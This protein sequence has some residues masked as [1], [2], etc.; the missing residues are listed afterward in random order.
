MQ[1]AQCLMR[2]EAEE[3][4]VRPIVHP[5]IRALSSFLLETGTPQLDPPCKPSR[6]PD[7]FRIIELQSLVE[8][9]R[10]FF[11][12]PRGGCIQ[13]VENILDLLLPGRAKA[14]TM[15]AVETHCYLRRMLHLRGFAAGVSP[16]F[17]PLHHCQS[18][19][20]LAC[21]SLASRIV[22]DSHRTNLLVTVRWQLML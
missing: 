8:Q 9:L 7:Q 14:T 16:E 4:I 19:I 3:D 17:L 22:C 12:P 11:F 2:T 1:N 5:F 21:P 13:C 20:T 10:V 15:F 18:G 6:A